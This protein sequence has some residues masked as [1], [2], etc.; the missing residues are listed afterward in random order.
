MSEKV[1]GIYYEV[2]A[3]TDALLKAADEVDKASKGMESSLGKSKKATDELNTGMGKMN[4][5]SAAVRRHFK[6]V[7]DD[8]LKMASTIRRAAIAMTAAKA[9]AAALSAGFLF[10]AGRTMAAIDEQQKFAEQVGGTIGAMRALDIVAGDAGASASSMRSAIDRLNFSLSQAER[11][12]GSA[13]D[14]IAALGLDART[15]IDMDADDRIAMIADRIQ[16]LGLDSAQTGDIMRQLGIRNRDLIAVMRQ[17]GDAIRDARQEVRDFGLELDRVDVAQIEMAND[18]LSRIGTAIQ[19]IRE[20]VAVALAPY[21]LVAAERFNEMAREAGGWGDVAQTA[22]DSVLTRGA[23][24]LDWFMEM[25]EAQVRWRLGMAQMDDAALQFATNANRYFY[26]TFDMLTDSLNLI[27]SAYNRLPTFGADI[28]PLVS[29]QERLVESSG[30]AAERVDIL[31]RRLA[32]L[33]GR[34]RPSE[35]IARA[36]ED[37]RNRAAEMVAETDNATR[38][39]FS[40]NDALDDAGGTAST[41]RDELEGLRD[42]YNRLLDQL[43]PVEAAKRK[44]VDDVALLKLAFAEGRIEVDE[45]AEAIRRLRDAFVGDG[46]SGDDDPVGYWERWLDAA[47]DAM[48]DFDRMA[49]SVIDDFHSGF[50]RAF[51]DMIFDSQDANEAFRALGETILRSVVRSI[52]QMAAQWATFKMIQIATGRQAE[53]AALA[54]AAAT[55]TGIASAYA[56]AAAAVSLATMGGNAAPATAGITATHAASR[57]MAVTGMA[58][59]GI[60]KVPREGTW[61]LDEGERVVGAALNEDLSEYLDQQKTGRESKSGGASS[62]TVHVNLNESSERAGDVDM[63]QPAD[64]GSQTIDIFVADIMGDGRSAAA[65]KT[66]FGLTSRG[67]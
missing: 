19:V 42:A 54:G 20:R 3:K 35:V 47:S 16:E 1:G 61:L 53:S 18:A 46:D 10:L 55:G 58:H 62:V 34:E 22:I 15:L 38:S 27:I 25:Q 23:G 8:G 37:V 28:E 43:F 63:S 36:L 45:Y 50:G 32:E 31:G 64:D 30:Q 11:G 7:S 29:V 65:L 24:L 52:A 60:A 56:P 4:P 48:T 51:E 40:F 12:S 14:A 5:V 67:R 9:A 41:T 57:A 66:K 17:G 59:D 39:T 49:S 44:M 6:G 33:E 26:S 13:A 2:D 21:L